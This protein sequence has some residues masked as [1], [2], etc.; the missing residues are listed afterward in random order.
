MSQSPDRHPAEALSQ[1]VAEFV[2]LVRSLPTE[3]LEERN[4]GSREMLSH[5]VYGWL[6]RQDSTIRALAIDLELQSG[7][8]KSATVGNVWQAMV[9]QPK[10]C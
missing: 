10:R 9:P 5:I 1:T 7:R 8:S 4:W 2:D 6:N 3:M